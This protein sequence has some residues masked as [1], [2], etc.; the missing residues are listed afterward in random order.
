MNRD[1]PLFKKIH[2]VVI[3]KRDFDVS[4]SMKVKRFIEDNKEA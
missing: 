3:R 2:R 4:S 1:K